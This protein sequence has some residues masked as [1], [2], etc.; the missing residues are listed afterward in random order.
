[1]KKIFALLAVASAAILL[2]GSCAKERYFEQ[3]L[4]NGTKIAVNLP[5]EKTFL[6]DNIGG[7]RPM[8]WSNGDS[9]AVNGMISM[10]LVIKGGDSLQTAQFEFKEAPAFPYSIAYPASIWTD[11]ATVTLPAVAKYIPLVGYQAVEG[12]TTMKA[13]T[14]ILHFAVKNG[15]TDS[16][17]VACLE[18]S[19]EGVQLNGAFT[20]DFENGTI[21]SAETVTAANNYV[22]M[23]INDFLG[24]E[25]IDVFIPV[26]AG[27]YAAKV[28]VIDA[29]GHFMEKE[30]S[31]REF[32]KGRIH[33]F[34]EF[35]YDPTGT[36]VDIHITTAAQ[37][38]AFA[39]AFNDGE[40]ETANPLVVSIDSDLD[41]TGVTPV[42][43]GS[44]VGE[45]YCSA[46]VL[47][48]NHKISNYTSGEPLIGSINT[49]GSVVDLTFD[50]TCSF[51]PDYSTGVKSVFGPF[52]DYLKGEIRNC[53]NKGNITINLPASGTTAVD[54]FC[55]GIA[56]RIREGKMIAC[57]NYGTITSADAKITSKA[58]YAGGLVGWLSNAD[59]VIDGCE[60]HG[61]ITHNATANPLVAGGIVAKCTGTVKNC[62]NDAAFMVTTV[63]GNDACKFISIGGITGDCTGAAIDS[64]SNSGAITSEST[65]KIQ[66]FGGVIGRVLLPS[67]VGLANTNSGN[68]TANKNGRNYYFG[69]IIGDIEAEAETGTYTFSG[70]PATGKIVVNGM[71]AGTACN[72]FL[73]GL[74]GRTA[75]A[76]TIQGQDLDSECD[77]LFNASAEAKQ[78]AVSAVGGILGGTLTAGCAPTILDCKVKGTGVWITAGTPTIKFKDAGFGGIL[79]NSGVGAT[80]KN[81][82][83]A[84]PVKFTDD[85]NCSGSNANILDFGGIAG[86]IYGGNSEIS[87]CTVGT[88]GIR[89][90]H[91]NNNAATATTGNGTGGIIGSFG[92]QTG[93][94]YTITISNCTNASR[95]YAYRC[96]AG[97]IAGFLD[98]ATVSN[99]SSTGAISNGNY[100]GG[101]VGYA[102][103]SSFTGCTFNNSEGIAST[104]GGSCKNYVGGLAGQT[105]SSAFTNCKTYFGA[106]PGINAKGNADA[107][108]A[109]GSLIGYSDAAS[110]ITSCKAGGYLQSANYGMP[111]DAST[112]SA[113]LDAT[114]VVSYA[115]GNCA[116]IP[117]PTAENVTLW[118]GK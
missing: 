68:I 102:S 100:T 101:L 85:K 10:P 18:V 117:A 118:D 78:T 11:N 4:S 111:G 66:N 47:G 83:V 31:S 7:K 112:K 27:T 62:T 90:Y 67:T 34:P 14:S 75:A 116:M 37:W 19:A 1:M 48:N 33:T 76:I 115:I 25:A 86:R 58:L 91:Y 12:A 71:E 43:V 63:R 45:T 8:Y 3:N 69:G 22:R 59:G 24:D 42:S 5:G 30:I 95:L 50:E 60:N 114:T 103:N 52:T 36:V 99:C 113:T 56:G 89:N 39:T 17:R 88:N 49:Y 84:M 54:K 23:N 20:V 61:A 53:V 108:V 105:V 104:S 72:L 41:F 29:K 35:A 73:G 110:T 55:G 94:T 87:D 96:A 92:Q 80:I 28:K 81:C 26:P 79:G 74:I 98:H 32:T 77:I 9:I 106:T 13:V 82:T 70:T 109:P 6:G 51:A 2:L 46:A 107:G 40:Y 97:G 57:K 64:C 16:C 38:N 65:V 44:Y 93:N 21:T 15:T